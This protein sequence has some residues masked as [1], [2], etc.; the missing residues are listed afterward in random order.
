MNSLNINNAAYNGFA[1][2]LEYHLYLAHVFIM[3]Y[4]KCLF[5]Q[6]ISANLIS[7]WIG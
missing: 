1:R 7:T 4:A 3:T 2:N 6:R 5:N